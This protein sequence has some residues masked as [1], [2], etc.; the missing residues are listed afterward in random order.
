MADVTP[1]NIVRNEFRNNSFDFF[2]QTL[3]IH[4]QEKIEKETKT[5]CD[6]VQTLQVESPRLN[7]ETKC[8]SGQILKLEGLWSIAKKGFWCKATH[9][10]ASKNVKKYLEFFGAW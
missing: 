4:D 9:P 2:L 1:L 5:K 8:N 3:K 6:I 10:S 7:A